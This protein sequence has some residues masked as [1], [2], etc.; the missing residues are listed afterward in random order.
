MK[1]KKSKSKS[2]Y[3]SHQLQLKAYNILLQPMFK[4]K[5]LYTLTQKLGQNVHAQLWSTFLFSSIA[6][7]Q[8][9]L[10]CLK[11]ELHVLPVSEMGRFH[12]LALNF[13]G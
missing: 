3:S 4:E 2:K 13:G 9:L 6:I 8:F 7:S 1:I 12:I 5:L 11:T 10:A